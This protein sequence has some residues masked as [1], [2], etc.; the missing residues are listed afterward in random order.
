MCVCM[1][2]LHKKIRI[3]ECMFIVHGK[4]SVIIMMMMT[5]MCVCMCVCVYVCDD[6]AVC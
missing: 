5:E 3:N 2:Y 6:C 1:H 4:R